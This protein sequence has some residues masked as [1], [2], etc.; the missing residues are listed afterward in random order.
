MT[1]SFFEWVQNLQ[2]FKWTEDEVNEKLDK[3]MTD[4]FANIWKVHQDT[5]LPLR[6]AA[7][8]T[9]LQR[10]TRARIHRGFD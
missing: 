6:T 2:N 1:V 3:A 10:V 8:V 7:F 9:A 4:A 5:G